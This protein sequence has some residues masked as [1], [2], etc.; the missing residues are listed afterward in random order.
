MAKEQKKTLRPA[1]LAAAAGDSRIAERKLVEEIKRHPENVNALYRLADLHLQRNEISPA[2]QLLQRAVQLAPSS[3]LFN[4]LGIAYRKIGR[5]DLALPVLKQAVVLDGNNGIALFN[6]GV[7]L[8]NFGESEKALEYIQLAGEKSTELR[9]SAIAASATIKEGMG[10]VDEAFVDIMAL[11]KA[12]HKDPV[13][14]QALGEI[15]QQHVKFSEHIDLAIDLLRAALE[16]K[17]ISPMQANTFYFLLGS[18]YQKKKDYDSAFIFF[19]KGHRHT[20]SR[21]NEDFEIAVVDQI[22]Q[23]WSAAKAATMDVNTPVKQ[24]LFFIVGMP[25]SGSTLVEQI[26][27]VY[28]ESAP[29]GESMFFSSALAEM[30]AKS[31]N[32]PATSGGRPLSADEAKNIRSLY[33]QRAFRSRRPAAVVTDKTLSNWMYVGQILQAF[34]NAKILWTRRDPRDTCLSCYTFDFAG[35]HPYLHDL[36]TLA[37]YHNR[38]QTM[39]QFWQER[40]PENVYAV[41]YEEMI[42]NPEKGIRELIDFCDLP[43]SDDYLRFHQV[44]RKITTASYNQVTQPIYTSA[45]GRWKAYEKH[46]APLLEELDLPNEVTS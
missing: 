10:R 39:M 25:R 14:L 11:I 3:P 1:P 45:S 36:R 23:S 5:P 34:P 46:L 17:T 27:A 26:L 22:R 37:R 35:D 40:Y 29:L 4:E 28:P 38:V 24:K 19:E 43:W 7:V 13:V 8:N 44:K 21:Y 15:L 6:Y 12:G 42:R 31:R 18:L 30:F 9:A 41:N 33:M 2:I 16:E 20:N 32:D